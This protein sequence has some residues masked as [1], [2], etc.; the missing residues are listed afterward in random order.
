MKAIAK[1]RLGTVL[2]V[3]AVVAI[4]VILYVGMGAAL[5]YPLADALHLA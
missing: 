2:E 3:S 5:L 1:Q 4:H